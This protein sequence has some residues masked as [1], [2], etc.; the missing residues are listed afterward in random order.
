MMKKMN[1]KLVIFCLSAFSS[2][3][4]AKA[5]KHK[6]SPPELYTAL[7]ACR[8]ISGNIER[9]ACFDAA[10]AKLAEA[11]AAQDVY[12]ADKAQIRE[13]R[14]KLFGLTLPNLG[15]FGSGDDDD[16]DTDQITQIS[17]TVK[18]AAYGPD[19]FI[20]TLDDGTVW[21]Q[22]DRVQIGRSP[23]SGM[24]IVVKKAALGS[25]KMNIAGQSAVRVKRIF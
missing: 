22:I 5:D 6:P 21:Q 16:Q 11:V 24:Q 1:W 15:I 12:I 4:F 7:V 9:L 17:S 23:K 10:A 3:A 20:V 2:P 14:R 19:G 8:G 18:S 25:F 13:T